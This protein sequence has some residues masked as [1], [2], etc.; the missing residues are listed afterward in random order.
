MHEQLKKRGSTGLPRQADA[1]HG[2][3]LPYAYATIKAKCHST[4]GL[5]TC[6]KEGHSCLRKIISWCSYPAKTWLR[7]G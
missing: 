5:R 1:W 7:Q 2:K 3:E 6:R 4:G